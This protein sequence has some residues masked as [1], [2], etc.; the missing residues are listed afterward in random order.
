MEARYRQRYLDLISNPKAMETL[1]ARAR[2]TSLIR[3]FLEDR[4]FVEIET[5]I[6]QSMAGGAL[7][8]PFITHHNALN[9]DLYLRIAT[10]L[11]LKR[12]VV[13]GFERVYEIGR[14]FRNEGIS[15]WHNP[16]YTMLEFY[17]SYANFEDLIKLSEEMISSLALAIKGTT[18]I[19]W[20]GKEL[21][22]TPPFKKIRMEEAVAEK[23]KLSLAEIRQGAAV[24][25]WLLT[26]GVKMQP[27]D[28]WGKALAAAFEASYEHEV[29]NP[30]FV[31]HFP[32][33]VSPLSRRNEADPE[34][35]DRFS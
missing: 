4:S 1:R 15:T 12:L 13:G 10:E 28:G 3:K 6:L 29:V 5:P 33:E 16:E 30:T 27:G 31:T 35:T 21:N 20:Q 8:K 34:I 25:K 14:C 7:A 23:L 17:M 18:K 11:Y 9:I 19:T 32:V 26:R 24:K 22:F 2:I